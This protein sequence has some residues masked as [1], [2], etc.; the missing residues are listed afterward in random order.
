MVGQLTVHLAENLKV[1]LS[2]HKCEPIDSVIHFVEVHPV[3]RY[4][5]VVVRKILDKGSGRRNDDLVLAVGVD[6]VEHPVLI[7][8]RLVGVGVALHKTKTVRK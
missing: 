2:F 8:V 5:V 7:V 6:D 3:H 1:R 4:R